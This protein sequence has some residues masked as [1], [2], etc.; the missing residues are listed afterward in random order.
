MTNAERE[1]EIKRYNKICTCSHK[2]G[3]HWYFIFGEVRTHDCRDC[4]C[5]KFQEKEND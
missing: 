3:R 4:K 5:K 1:K 2:N